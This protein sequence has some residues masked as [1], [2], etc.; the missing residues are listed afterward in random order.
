MKLNILTIVSVAA[1]ALFGTPQDVNAKD[2]ASKE[3]AKA[4]ATYLAV[5]DN[6]LLMSDSLAA[7]SL[8][9]EFKKSRDVIHEIIG[10]KEKELRDAEQDLE[11]S[12]TTLSAEDYEEKRSEFVKQFQTAKSELRKQMIIKEKAFK[13]AEAKLQ[14]EIINVVTELSEKRGYDVVLPR[15][16]V[17][18]MEGS[19]DITEDVMAALNK[20]VKK[21]DIVKKK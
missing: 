8:N 13:K 12:R 15:S 14:Q 3:A 10:K 1:L 2:K 5:V 9:D 20:R 11:V 19:V 7:K 6:Q 4:K 16:A 17:I 21:I 18:I